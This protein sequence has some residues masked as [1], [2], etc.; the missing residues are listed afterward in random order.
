MQPV[1]YVD[2]AL[3]NNQGGEDTY[4]RLKLDNICIN[5]TLLTAVR[6]PQGRQSILLYPNPTSHTFTLELP[7]PA[8]PGTS[9]RISGITGQRLLQQRAEA[10]SRLQVF[11][12]SGLP[13]GMYFVQVWQEGRIAGVGRVVKQ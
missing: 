1:F 7:E 3:S 4:S 5:G 2:N 11:D 8:T 9:F 6:N 13:A 12:L 10:G